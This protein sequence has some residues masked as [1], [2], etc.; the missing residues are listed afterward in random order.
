MGRP[1]YEDPAVAAVTGETLRPGGFMLTDRSVG[2]CALPPGARVAD[3]GCGNG[4]TVRRLRERFGLAAVGFDASLS[5]LRK[6]PPGGLVVQGRA[7]ALPVVSGSMAAVF[8]ECVL[9]LVPSPAE[10]L[11]ECRRVLAPEGFLI[12]ADLYQRFPAEAGMPGEHGASCAAGARSRP[13]MERCVRDKGFALMRW[14]DH[15]RLLKELAAR[16]VFAHGSLDRFWT[17]VGLNGPPG[18]CCGRPGYG[19][20]ICRKAGPER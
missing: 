4:A 10:A 20:M 17:H 8:C 5:M 15:T 19:L 3:I 1:L 2:L 18:D 9:S 16:I 14:E 11:R 12:L 7:E 6:A 13:D